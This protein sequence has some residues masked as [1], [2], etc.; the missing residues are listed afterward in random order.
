MISLSQHFIRSFRSRSLAC[1]HKKSTM[2]LP[3]YFLKDFG[4]CLYPGVTVSPCGTINVQWYLFFC[5]LVS[6]V[7]HF[8]RGF[9]LPFLD[10]YYFCLF[11]S[12]SSFSFHF[13]FHFLY[14]FFLLIYL[15]NLNFLFLN[16]LFF[17]VYF[18]FTLNNMVHVQVY[19]NTLLLGNI[20]QYGTDS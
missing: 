15:V 20:L 18:F 8:L 11:F 12:F 9:H 10:M 4:D 16:L 13:H 2:V 3:S 14:L 19:Q 7:F 17:N 6:L 5:F 1:L